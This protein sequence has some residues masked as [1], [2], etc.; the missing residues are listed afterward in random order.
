M[1]RYW[2]LSILVGLFLI[3]V[4]ACSAGSTPTAA[5]QSTSVA[6]VMAG[7]M[8]EHGL[9][10]KDVERIEVGLNQRIIH[11]GGS[12]L[13][14]H[15]ALGAQFSLTFSLAI[16][17][18][19]GSNDVVLY[20]DP[21]MWRDPEVLAV[22]KKIQTYADPNAKGDNEFATTIKTAYSQYTYPR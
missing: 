2:L 15:D 19:K 22:S 16:R 13:E 20:T 10:A 9:K 14:P 11:H 1:R 7:L 12:I 21:A 6:T 17:L 3:A 18:L 5:P 4:F 8:K